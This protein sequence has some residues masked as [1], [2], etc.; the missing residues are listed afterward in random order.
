MSE[1]MIVYIE[2]WGITTHPDYPASE[3][4]LRGVVT[5]HPRFQDGEHITD[6]SPIRELRAGHVVS[7]LGTV[8]ELGKPDPNALGDAFAVNREFAYLVL[9][10]C[11][12]TAPDPKIPP[13][14]AP[15]SPAASP[16]GLALALAAYPSNGSSSTIQ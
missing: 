2:N 16:S 5:G 7:L 14:V 15:H 13:A 1:P 4:C 6:S 12:I 9:L 10:L 8:Y 11:F 3:P